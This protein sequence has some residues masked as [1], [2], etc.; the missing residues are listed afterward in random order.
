MSVK[1]EGWGR[2]VRRD[3]QRLRDRVRGEGCEVRGESVCSQRI[4][5]GGS[6]LPRAF[7]LA[8]K[9]QLSVATLHACEDE[10]EGEGEGEG[11]C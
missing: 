3:V 2:R 4:H 8:E 9:V 1:G 6:G 10:G 11:E 5:P 7:W